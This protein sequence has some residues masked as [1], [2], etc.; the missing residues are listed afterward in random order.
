M[1][2]ISKKYFLGIIYMLFASSYF[3]ANITKKSTKIQVSDAVLNTLNIDLKKLISEGKKIEAI[4]KNR[5]VTGSGL[6]EAK[7]YIDSFK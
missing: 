4:K 3:I 6:K 2:L 1:N 7:E 5:I